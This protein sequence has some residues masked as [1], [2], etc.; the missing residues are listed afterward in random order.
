M[1]AGGSGMAPVLS[2]LRQ[3]ARAVSAAGA[4]LLR[5]PDGGGPVLLDAIAALGARLADFGFT[6]VVG[7][8]VHEA[9]DEY[10]DGELEAA[11]RLHVRAAA[12]DRGGRGDAD[13]THGDRPGADL[14]RQVH[15]LRAE[16]GGGRGR[17]GRAPSA[18]RRRRRARVRLVHAR[19]RRA[20]LYEDVTID[21]QPS[22]HRHL[23]RGWPVSFED[24]RGTWDD[25]LDGAALERLVRLPRPRRA[26]GAAFYQ[27][28]QPRSSSRS[29][30]RCARRRRRG[31]SR[32]STPSGSSSCATVLQIPA[33]VEHGL[34]FA[35]ATVARDCLSD[36]VAT[37]VV[38][39]R[40]R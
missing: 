33:F 22:V 4:V 30:A 34:W 36:S 10:L 12:D 27:A 38:P 35:L 40:R 14:H 21:T 1:I 31:C 3:L 23:A 17:A 32:T 19:R 25:A 39:R 29:R 28:R 15:D 8:F 2:L 6:P 5:R 20:T 13:R 11:R 7:R 9:V 16:A 18:A 24:G 37:C 26:V